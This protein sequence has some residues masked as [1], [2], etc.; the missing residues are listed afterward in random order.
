[1]SSE[2][3]RD[4]FYSPTMPFSNKLASDQTISELPPTSINLSSGSLTGTTTWQI[5][6]GNQ[7]LD[8]MNTYIRARMTINIGTDLIRMEN[9]ATCLFQ[10]GRIYINGK[11]MA[12]SNNWVQDSLFSKR[13]AQGYA[14]NNGQNEVLYTGATA[15]TA[16]VPP[17]TAGADYKFTSCD[18]L[19]AFFLRQSNLIIPPNS[20]LMIELTTA[21]SN[22]R[23]QAVVGDSD[24]SAL[25]TYNVNDLVL[26]ARYIKTNAAMEEKNKRALSF[27][28]LHSFKSTVVGTSYQKNYTAGNNLIGIGVAF[29]DSTSDNQNTTK[30]FN[31]TIFD[32]TT[33]GSVI[34]STTTDRL[35]RLYVRYGGKQLLNSGWDNTYGFKQSYQQFLAASGQIID[36]KASVESQTQWETQGAIYLARVIRQPDNQQG[37]TEIVT[38]FTLEPT[39]YMLVFHLQQQLVYLEYGQHGQLVNTVLSI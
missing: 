33:S 8:L 16:N 32:Y 38:N 35:D 5:K 6:T 34:N 19:D 20:T 28:T 1:M 30:V 37:T 17:G 15:A 3:V 14:A 2:N 10:N 22:G 25:T 29:Q 11:R 27:I 24:N 23:Y 31:S 9:P 13:V 39:C 36:Q 12:S 26:V 21:P 18:Y 4:E 7:S